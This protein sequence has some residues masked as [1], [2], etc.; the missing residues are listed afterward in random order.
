MNL[1]LFFV[2]IGLPNEGLKRTQNHA[3]HISRHCPKFIGR[4][5]LSRLGLL[6]G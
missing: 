4:L 6:F 5:V 3:V 2:I 1:Q